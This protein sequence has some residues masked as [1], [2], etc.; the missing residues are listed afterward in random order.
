MAIKIKNIDYLGIN[1][2]EVYAK[3]EDISLNKNTISFS[4]AQYAEGSASSFSKISYV[5]D[6]KING[7][8]PFKQAYEYLK[9]LPEY[10]DAEDV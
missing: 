7:E 5:C 1:I 4:L 8:N 6:Y 10:V 9:T 3:V 2:P